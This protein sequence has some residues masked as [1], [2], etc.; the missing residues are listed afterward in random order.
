LSVCNRFVALQLHN[1][2]VHLP[3]LWRQPQAI[4]AEI[5]HSFLQF[6]CEVLLLRNGGRNMLQQ[7]LRGNQEDVNLLLLMTSLS[8]LHYC[9]H[10]HNNH[11]SRSN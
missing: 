8:S 4:I 9:C 7:M 1:P 6:F 11:V 10:N 5:Q 2:A 3:Q